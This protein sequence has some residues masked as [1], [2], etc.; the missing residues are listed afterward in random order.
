MTL[1]TGFCC[2][3]FLAKRAE[4]SQVPAERCLGQQLGYG[5]SFNPGSALLYADFSGQEYGIA[6][7]F[8]EDPAMISDYRNGDPYLGFAKRLGMVPNDATKKTHSA[9]RDQ[10]KVATG[11]GVLYGA[12]EETVARA[13]GMTPSKA[14]WILQQHCRTYPTFWRWRQAV[15][16]HAR[17]TGELRT[18]YGWRWLICDDDNSRSISNFPMQGQRCRT[19]SPSHVFSRRAWPEGL[20]AGP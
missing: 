1:E 15:V 11:L 16:N 8:S 3:L 12:R 17:I 9:L 18:V 4:T 19:T 14:K 5:P 6:A 10:L 20:R 13:G 2:R 7:Y